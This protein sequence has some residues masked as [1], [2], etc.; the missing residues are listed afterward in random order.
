MAISGG[1]L[2]T[3]KTALSSSP[4]SAVPTGFEGPS[5]AMTLMKYVPFGTVAVSQTRIVSVTLCRRTFHA[6]SPSR[7]YE[8]SYDNS[9]SFSSSARQMIVCNPFWYVRRPS[10]AD[11][12]PACAF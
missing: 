10:G 5:D 11:P 4:V 12:P 6:G 2:S 3:S 9:S 7:R 8:M 1:V